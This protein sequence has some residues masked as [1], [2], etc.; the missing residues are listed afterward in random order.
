MQLYYDNKVATSIA[1]DP[2]QHERTKHIES[3]GNFFK[4][5]GLV[6]ATHALTRLRLRGSVKIVVYYYLLYSIYKAV[7]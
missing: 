2:V 6:V 5:K 7:F 1:H 4:D 3:G